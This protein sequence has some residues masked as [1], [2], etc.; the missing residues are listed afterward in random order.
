[1]AAPF[2]Q[3][4]RVDSGDYQPGVAENHRMMLSQQPYPPHQLHPPPFQALAPHHPLMSENTVPS[5]A[6]PQNTTQVM[7][8]LNQSIANLTSGGCGFVP[9]VPSGAAPG[10][11]PGD[12][13]LSSSPGALMNA[14]NLLQQNIGALQSLIPLMAQ[15]QQQQPVDSAH[16]AHLKQ[17]QAAAS[18]GVASVISQLALAAAN[19]LPQMGLSPPANVTPS[20]APPS[21]IIPSVGVASGYLQAGFSQPENLQSAVAIR[22][23]PWQQQQQLIPEQQ[24]QQLT[25]G[26]AVGFGSH[27]FGF[28][29]LECEK[30]QNPEDSAGA[31]LHLGLAS[32]TPA[33]PESLKMQQEQQHHFQPQP[34]QQQQQQ[35]KQSSPVF[36][37]SPTVSP[38]G[39][40]AALPVAKSQLPLKRKNPDPV[41]SQAA[42]DAPLNGTPVTTPAADDDDDDGEPFAEGEFDIV[43]MDPVELLAEHTHFCEICG[44]GFKRDANLRMHMRGHGDEYKTPEALSRP[45]KTNSL[46]PTGAEKAVK[47]VRYSCPFAG[48]KRNRQHR[49]FLP[50]KTMLCVKNHYRRTHCPKMLACSKCGAKRFSVVADLKTH[51]KHCG[52]DRWLCSCGTSFSR[53]DKLAGHL[54]LF[55][56]HRPAN[57]T[58]TVVDDAA[59]GAGAIAGPSGAAPPVA[60][61]KNQPQ[62]QGQ[63]R[64]AAFL[65]VTAAAAG[66]AGV[67]PET[68]AAGS[69]CGEGG[70][71]GGPG[72]VRGGGQD[73]ECALSSFNLNACTQP[74]KGPEEEREVMVY[75]HPSE[76]QPGQRSLADLVTADLLGSAEKAARLVL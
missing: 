53:K 60:G 51:E 14:L 65:A 34:Q 37:P 8:N 11:A 19:I 4:I 35:P 31:Q 55:K 20:T 29:M 26:T 10:A 74:H 38:G 50:L 6:G 12:L 61:F 32:V 45:D 1:M 76:H 22:Q 49:R 52:R 54:A 7:M 48:C 41:T 15:Q 42:F 75:S 66:R 18:A 33:A 71:A 63:R 25:Q 24:Q 9:G 70:V 21:A 72:G 39:D 67:A 69:S 64:Q 5:Q 30:A 36:A 44:K 62:Q 56:G 27:A 17:Q 2:F 13:G 28:Q 3:Q 43:Q 58:L 46:S 16:A 23:Q 57:P 40:T 73:R 68:S 59:A 47:P